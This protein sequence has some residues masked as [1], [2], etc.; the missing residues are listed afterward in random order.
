MKYSELQQLRVQA[1]RSFFH[2]KTTPIFSRGSCNRQ[3]RLAVYRNTGKATE[4]DKRKFTG[5]FDLGKLRTYFVEDTIAEYVEIAVSGFVEIQ[6]NLRI[7]SDAE[8][9]V[10][11]HYFVWNTYAKVFR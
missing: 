6:C 7:N 4:N 5:D 10:H 1:N 3:Q 2:P 11:V 8:I 9:V